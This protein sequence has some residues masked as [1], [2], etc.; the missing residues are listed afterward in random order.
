VSI[1]NA[2]PTSSSLKFPTGFYSKLKQDHDLQA[3]MVSATELEVWAAVA[4]V[5][6]EEAYLGAYSTT[7][8]NSPPSQIISINWDGS[9][10]DTDDGAAFWRDLIIASN[11]P[12]SGLTVKVPSVVDDTGKVSLI[13]GVKPTMGSDDSF[14][15]NTSK[16]VIMAMEV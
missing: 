6:G 7:L 12:D 14:W 11:A 10:N 8:S 1:Y 2:L 15:E 4:M 9:D 13:S 5:R 3:G 16:R